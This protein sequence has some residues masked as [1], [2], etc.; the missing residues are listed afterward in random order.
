MREVADAERIRAFMRA[1]GAKARDAARVYFTGG[2]TAVLLGWRP[3]TID[4]DLRIDPESDALLR[5]I[6][7]LK[8]TL[9]LNVELACP[10]D[11]IPEL[12]GWEGRSPF[13]AQEGKLSFHHY[14]FY[15][16]ALAKIERGHATDLQDVRELIASG[17]IEPRRALDFFRQIEPQIYRYPALDPASFRR[18]V[19]EALEDRR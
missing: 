7:R 14:D 1:L 3:S 13:I 10:A 16:Q 15:A 2:V 17:R 18:A 12:A 4:V 11:F 9:K 8:E 19:E 6:P 5:A